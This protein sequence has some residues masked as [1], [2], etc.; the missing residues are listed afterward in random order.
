MEYKIDECNKE[1][2]DLVL[3]AQKGDDKVIDKIIKKMENLVRKIAN[4]NIC[5]M[6]GNGLGLDDLIQEGNIALVDAIYKYDPSFNKTFSMYAKQRIQAYV[7][8]AIYNCSCSIKVPLLTSRKMRQLS[9]DKDSD[10]TDEELA[11]KYNISIDKVRKLLIKKPNICSMNELISDDD[12]ETFEYYL[13]SNNDNPEDN[14]KNI[15]FSES[16]KNYLGELSEKERFIIE[17]FY[18]INDGDR[19]TLEELGKRYNCSSQNLYALKNKI[20]KK[21]KKRIEEDG[22]L[23]YGNL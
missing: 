18:E 19:M 8:Y 4:D 21:L 15:E 14:I 11:Q 17:S 23:Q 9:A 5:W 7:T 20:L 12:D 13:S 3:L 2:I 22:V 6:M 10:M 1:L 16:L